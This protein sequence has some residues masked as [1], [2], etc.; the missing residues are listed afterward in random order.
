MSAFDPK[1]TLSYEVGLTSDE[2]KGLV[3]RVA[4]R[5]EP[6]TSRSSLRAYPEHGRSLVICIGHFNKRSFGALR[7]SYRGVRTA[8]P[9]KFSIPSAC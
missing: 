8:A 2:W 4:E 1:Q 3:P 6:H 9:G 7:R 5:D